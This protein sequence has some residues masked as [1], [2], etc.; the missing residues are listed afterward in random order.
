MTPRQYVQDIVIPTVRE[1]RDKRR[2][3]RRA[4]LACIVVYHIADYLQT[5]GERNVP[6]TMKAR[7]RTFEVVRGVCNG[8]K[9]RELRNNHEVAFTPGTDW[10]RPPA[11]TGVMMC[12]I[13]R[14]GDLTGGREF[15]SGRATYD[16]YASAK[17]LLGQFVS[18]YPDQL[19]GCDIGDC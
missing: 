14:F 16:I 2:C 19:S 13:S 3:R 11:F 17:G 4:Y 15:K 10:Y 5:A 18:A 12:G 6:K 8:A 9:H 1:S 7:T